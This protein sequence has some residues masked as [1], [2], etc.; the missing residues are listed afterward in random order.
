MTQRVEVVSIGYKATHHW[1]MVLFT[2]LAITGSVLFSI[3][4]MGWLAW[5]AGR[6]LAAVFRTDP[7]TAG[8]QLFRALHAFV[9]YVWG[10][11]LIIYGINLLAFKKIEIFRPLARP[12]SEQIREAKAVMSHYLAGRPMPP[13]VARNLDRHNVLVAYLGVLLLIII[14]LFAVSGVGLTLFRPDPVTAGVLLLLHDIAFGLSIL[15]LALHFFAVSH[16]SN[17]PLLGAMFT[18]GKVDLEW[19]RH[20][21]PRYLERRGVA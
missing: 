3:E 6:P 11:A 2:F 16:P 7:L 4:L 20:H 12:I 17:R 14:A 1:N 13:D 8:V 19:A 18:D 9:G 5:A 15:F 21:M 10:I